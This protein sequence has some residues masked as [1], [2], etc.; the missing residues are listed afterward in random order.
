MAKGG[1]PARGSG[2]R[3]RRWWGLAGLGGCGEAAAV[4]A[5]HR[6]VGDIRVAERRLPDLDRTVDSY[7]RGT[8]KAIVTIS[9]TSIRGMVNS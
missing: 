2:A 5:G 3:R 8:P 4:A 6:L 7:D 1:P 9:P